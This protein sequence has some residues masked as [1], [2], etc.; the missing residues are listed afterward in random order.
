MPFR[1]LVSVAALLVIAC[2]PPRIRI[3]WNRAPAFVLPVETPVSV[4]VE[5]DGSQPVANAVVDGLIGLGRGQVLNKWAAVGPVYAELDLTL[6][7]AQ[8]NVVAPDDAQLTV[9]VTPTNWQFQPGS[10]RLDARIE[11]VDAKDP[12]KAP[13]YSDT[14]WATG[15]VIVMSTQ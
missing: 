10:G 9:R 14:Y 1:L 8:H 3:E 2:G 15:G 6:R 11:V 13:L 4:K 12:A 7:Q 5:A